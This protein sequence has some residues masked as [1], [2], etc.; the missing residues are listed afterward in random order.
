MEQTIYR[1]SR[2]SNHNSKLPEFPVLMKA[3]N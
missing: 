1:E 2:M 3:I